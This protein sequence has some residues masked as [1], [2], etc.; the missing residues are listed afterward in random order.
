[1]FGSKTNSRFSKFIFMVKKYILIYIKKITKALFVIKHVMR[2]K[3]F[4]DI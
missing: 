4:V 2:G 1:M 3:S